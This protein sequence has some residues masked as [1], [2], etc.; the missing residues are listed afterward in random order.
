MFGKKK[1]QSVINSVDD[2]RSEAH[3]FQLRGTG[4]TYESYRT[5]EYRLYHKLADDEMIPILDSHLTKLFS[6]E[7]DSANSNILE[8]T[9]LSA[10]AEALPDLRRQKVD[11]DDML[12]RLICRRDADRKDLE[13][14]R[15]MRIKER[16]DIF[17]EYEKICMA[18]DK[19]GEV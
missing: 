18:L 2:S 7:V 4:P 14:L 6:G 5:V 17:Q 13:R 11:H 10:V 3:D 12:R 8:A 19:C 16:D 1:N 9:I 15:D